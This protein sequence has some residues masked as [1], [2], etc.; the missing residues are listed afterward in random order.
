MYVCM[1]THTCTERERV[2]VGFLPWTA[3]YI[4]Q[5]SFVFLPSVLSVATPKFITA[6]FWIVLMMQSLPVYKTIVTFTR[7]PCMLQRSQAILSEI[8]RRKMITIFLEKFWYNVT[9]CISLQQMRRD[10]WI[11]LLNGLSFTV[12]WFFEFVME[13]SFPFSSLIATCCVY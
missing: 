7:F 10:F 6:H 2:H 5:Q 1:Y 12:L 8:A 4:P 9:E 3:K 11:N 13:A